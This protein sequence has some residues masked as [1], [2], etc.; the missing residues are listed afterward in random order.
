M[1]F[2]SPIHIAIA[3]RILSLLFSPSFHSIVVTFFLF[4][5]PPFLF[6]SL[7]FCFCSLPRV[8]LFWDFL[9]GSS[10]WGWYSVF[11]QSYFFFF[12]LPIFDPYNIETPLLSSSFNQIVLC[13]P[14]PPY[15]TFRCRSHTNTHISPLE[16]P[17]LNNRDP[18]VQRR[19]Y[20]KVP[21][22]LDFLPLLYR[23]ELLSESC[24]VPNTFLLL[25]FFTESLFLLYY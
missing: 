23:Q 19:R 2:Q 9:A 17:L 21:F 6:S 14:F 16:F 13:F 22:F 12:L 18:Q 1:R 5:L 25:W 8:S 20:K 4:I 10:R 7:F 11:C 3:L 24:D 15:S